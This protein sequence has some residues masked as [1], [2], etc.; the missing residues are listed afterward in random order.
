[1]WVQFPTRPPMSKIRQHIPGFVSGMDPET[2]EFTTTEEL[3]NIPWIK[4]LSKFKYFTRFSLSD[5][6]L[7]IELGPD[8]YY[9]VGTIDNIENINLPKW[10][11]SLTG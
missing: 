10:E 9:V 5:H 3:L 7:M 1:M 8:I 6:H 2:S 4:K 11:R